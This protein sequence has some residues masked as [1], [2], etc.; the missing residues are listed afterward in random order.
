MPPV[1]LLAVVDEDD[2]L[3]VEIEPGDCHDRVEEEVLVRD[4]EL[5]Q[6]VHGHVFLVVG[7]IK[8]LLQILLVHD[9]STRDQLIGVETI[10]AD[11]EYGEVLDVG[12]VFDAAPSEE[13]AK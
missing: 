8:S 2:A 6:K 10:F 11:G 9:R 7:G 13:G 3:C 5:P 4:Q 12:I 1:L